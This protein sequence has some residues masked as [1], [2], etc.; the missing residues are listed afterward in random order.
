MYLFYETEKSYV[1]V[2]LGWNDVA[3]IEETA[4]RIDW[5]RFS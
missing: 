3:V 1:L 2:S 5:T 4:E